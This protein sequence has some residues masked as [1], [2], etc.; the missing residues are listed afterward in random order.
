M[1]FSSQSLNH[2]FDKPYQTTESTILLG[3]SVNGMD[4]INRKS[5][6]HHSSPGLRKPALLSYHPIKYVTTHVPMRTSA[7]LPPFSR[8]SPT[9]KSHLLCPNLQLEVVTLMDY[10]GDNAFRIRKMHLI[11]KLGRHDLQHI[12]AHDT[13]VFS[14]QI[15]ATQALRCIS[16]N[17]FAQHDRSIASWA[18]LISSSDVTLFFV[19]RFPN[20]LR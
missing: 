2:E 10:R 7:T 16:A 9:P 13:R 18:Q 19:S 6:S 20:V 5:F 4:Y 12:N 15:H 1:S 8:S 14:P 17:L 3:T 11:H